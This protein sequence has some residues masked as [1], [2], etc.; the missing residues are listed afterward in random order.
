MS[1][2]QPTATFSKDPS[3][4]LDYTV[5]W[6]DF[7]V[8][9]TIATVTWTI[10]AGIGNAGALFSRTLAIIFLSGGTAGTGYNIT[11]HITTAGGR[12]DSRTFKIN[13]L[14]K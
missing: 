12:A 7:L 9:D 13:V 4:V 3:A 11:C 14:N 1:V 2:P 10:D 5:D 8:D 6:S